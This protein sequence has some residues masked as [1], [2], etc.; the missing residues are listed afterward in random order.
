LD[1]S[2][3]LRKQPMSLIKK[4][5]SLL[6]VCMILHNVSFAQSL[7]Y[8]RLIPVATAYTGIYLGSMAYLQFVWYKDKEQVPFEFYNDSKG[9]KQIDKFGHMYG[10]YLESYLGVKSLKWSGVPSRQAAW[11]GG[12]MGFIMQLPIEIWDGMY[13]GWGF[14][15][16]DVG[17]NALGSALVISQ[18]L[19]FQDQPIK[20][21]F[22]FSR[23]P[24][25]KLANGYLGNG[26]NEVFYD[27]NGHTYWIT[28]GLNR[29]IQKDFIPDWLDLAIGYSAGGM[30]GEFKNRTS[31]R[32]VLI[33]ETER[34]R[35]FLLSFDIDFSKIPTHNK[36]LKKFF[37][38]LFIL[39]VPFPS[40][41]FNTKGEILMHPVYF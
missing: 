41:E 7:K 16:S 29:I 35:Q 2:I 27:Y 10:S 11:I 9:Y 6:F 23:S 33:P 17:A 22:T 4:G 26:F 5:L 15:W 36:W 8:E 21:K 14:S 19:I 31:Y 30:Y 37:S 3:V 25:A 20:Y 40:I 13:E 34:Y 32:G 18:E 38:H 39:K 28:I 12:S 24:Y 1:E